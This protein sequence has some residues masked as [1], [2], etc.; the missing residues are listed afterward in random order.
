MTERSGLGEITLFGEL[1]INVNTLA[2]TQVS[3][4]NWSQIA[5]G[6]GGAR[7]YSLA[8]FSNGTLWAWGNNSFGQLGQNNTISYASPVQIVGSW[9]QAASGDR[10]SLGIHADGT[11]WAWGAGNYG[12]VGTK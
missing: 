2:P 9:I 7:A 1:G 6:S 10:H 12:H 5:Q 11:L 8:I 4:G 3:I